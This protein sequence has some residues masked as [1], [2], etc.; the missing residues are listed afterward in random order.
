ML[1][2]RQRIVQGSQHTA[3][4]GVCDAANNLLPMQLPYIVKGGV[5]AQARYASPVADMP[6]KN[7]MFAPSC[8]AWTLVG[9][10]SCGDSSTRRGLVRLHGG[11][12][13]EGGVEGAGRISFCVHLDCKP[14]SV[15]ILRSM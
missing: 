10:D 12:P 8:D 1:C 4:D 5:F 7:M 3:R 6:I 13:T 11:S 9:T 14:V 15:A 2:L